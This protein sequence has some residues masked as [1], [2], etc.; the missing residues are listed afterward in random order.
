[1]DVNTYK[2]YENIVVVPYSNNVGLYEL[3][4]INLIYYFSL[5]N[6][7]SQILYVHT[8][9]ILRENSEYIQNWVDLMLYFG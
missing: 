8:K 3:K 4:T 5:L 7:N 2:Q 6:P 1:M 9:G